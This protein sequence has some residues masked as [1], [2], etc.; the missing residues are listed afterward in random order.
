MAGAAM[1]EGYKQGLSFVCNPFNASSSAIATVEWVFYL[2][3]VRCMRP[4]PLGHLPSL[5]RLPPPQILDFM[6]T[7]FIVARGKWDQ[8]IFLHV[9]HHSTIFIIYWFLT[10]AA[11]D[12]DIFYT[13]IANS[14]VHFFM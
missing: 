14:I 3:K 6:D 13:I 11:Y 5:L 2:S 10:V 7:V 1:Y 4:R 9:Y 8:F 12:G